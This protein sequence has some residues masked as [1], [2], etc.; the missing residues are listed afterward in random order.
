MIIRRV[1]SLPLSPTNV[2]DLF[3]HVEVGDLRA[4]VVGDDQEYVHLKVY[5]TLTG[6]LTIY[7]NEVAQYTITNYNDSVD[8][9]VDINHGAVSRDGDLITV[10]LPESY[11][12][13]S[14]LLTVNDRE[15]SIATVYVD[16]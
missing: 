2:N 15:F 11:E 12:G 16:P 14:I 10:T 13:E 6:P 8:Y 5:P 3:I 9:V 7:N 4:T 1:F